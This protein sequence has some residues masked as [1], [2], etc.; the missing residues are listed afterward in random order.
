M[1]EDEKPFK[2]T[3][4]WTDYPGS[5]V[6]GGGL[7]NDLDLRVRKPD[8]TYVYP[9]GARNLSSLDKIDYCNDTSGRYDQSLAGVRFTPLKYPATLD[10]VSINLPEVIIDDTLID[11]M[12]GFN[13]I[14]YK[15]SGGTVQQ[16][17]FC[18]K[19][20]YA[21]RG[22]ITLPVG[23]SVTEDELLVC[24]E[25]LSEPLYISY[26]SGND[27]R[28]FFKIGGTDQF[29][30]NVPH[31]AANFRTEV[32]ATDYDR[33]NN[34]VS[35]Q[36]NKPQ[37][38]TYTAEVSAHN[39][40]HGPQ[41]YALIMSGMNGEAPTVGEI[42]LN[43]D[44]PNAPAATMLSR[45]HQSQTA[46]SLNSVYG[47]KF[48]NVYSDKSEF[49]IQTE[50]DSVVSVRY[51]VSGLPEVNAGD[52]DLSKLYENGTHIEFEYSSLEDYQDGKWWLTDVTG[53]FVSPVEK[54]S[55]DTTYYLVS[56]VKDGGPYDANE[57]PGVV[58]DPQ[59]LGLSSSG[60]S[61]CNI[62]TDVDCILSVMLLTALFSV[63]IRWLS[64]RRKQ[65]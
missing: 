40:A 11:F 31:I 22:R 54:L 38:G 10:S 63:W 59:V 60:A 41:P 44:Q 51:A 36:I 49:S 9:D 16:E 62:G 46:E 65:F 28:G 25:G 2:A 29:S 42:G 58:D 32:P 4:G 53:T 37:S 26:S 6:S 47:T 45:I 50:E 21:D 35:V 17:I 13:I 64:A 7:V 19:Y 24:I 33:V 30:N 15:V 43:P 3:L 52:L 5:E 8:G 48:E 14:V 1:K 61:G 56:A 27:S 12:L 20:N 18:K 39:I 34:T 55:P 23:V 57:D